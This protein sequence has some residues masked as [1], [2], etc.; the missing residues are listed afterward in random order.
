MKRVWGAV[1]VAAGL[2]AMP[3]MAEEIGIEA[4]GGLFAHSVDE[5]GDT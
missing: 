3:A 1:A 4:R 2:A 5:S